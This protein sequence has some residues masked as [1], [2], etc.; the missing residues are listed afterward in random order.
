MVNVARFRGGKEETESKGSVKGG[1]VTHFNQ[2]DVFKKRNDSIKNQIHYENKTFVKNG[3]KTLEGIE[4][5]ESNDFRKP[6]E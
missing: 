2:I 6:L 1:A 4:N 5:L 3:N